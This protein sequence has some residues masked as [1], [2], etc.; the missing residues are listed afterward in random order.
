MLVL[1]P[2]RGVTIRAF[3][4]AF[5]DQIAAAG[6]DFFVAPFIPANPGLKMRDAYLKEVL[7]FEEHLVPQVITRDPASMTTLLRALKDKGYT[8]CDLNAGCPFPMIVKRG[9]GSGLFKTPDVLERLVETGVNEMGPGNFSVKTRL[10]LDSPD[11]LEKLLAIYNRYPLAFLTV[12]ARTARQMYSGTCDYARLAAIARESKNPLV[13]NGDLQV[14]AA[15]WPNG[16]TNAMAGRSFVRSLGARYD[17]RELL[18]RY[19]AISAAELAG[20][21]DAPVLGRVKELVSYWK[22][23]SPWWARR[24][25]SVKICRTLAELTSLV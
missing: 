7:P 10:G 5:K 3:R 8:A 23:A 4:A 20:C 13:W 14:D 9:R 2:L 1:A 19:I 16:C 12:H 11:E 6:F 18:K 21:G 15:R 22:E 25:N 17:S 24:W